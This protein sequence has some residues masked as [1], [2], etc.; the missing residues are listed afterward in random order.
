[1]TLTQPSPLNLD[2]A[3]RDVELMEPR[4]N[5][6]D[7]GEIFCDG[8][9]NEEFLSGLSGDQSNEKFLSALKN[10]QEELDS[11]INEHGVQGRYEN[12]EDFHFG[13]ED[14]IKRLAWNKFMMLIQLF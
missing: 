12:L 14:S 2:M 5:V 7:F 13:T 8:V 11:G 1:M 9:W 6:E 10:N 3:Y 4:Q